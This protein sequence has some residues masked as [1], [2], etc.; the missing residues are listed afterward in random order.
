MIDEMARALMPGGQLVVIETLGTGSEVPSAPNP[1]LA[2]LYGW[3]EEE[4]GMR[5]TVIRTDYQFPDV[6]TAA[7]VTG[8][9]FGEAFAERVRREGWARVPECTGIW[10]RAV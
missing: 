3:L 1:G 8:F 9:F 7:E 2:E 5:R 4:R 10:S 6:A